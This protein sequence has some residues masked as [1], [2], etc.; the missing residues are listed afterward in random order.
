MIRSILAADPGKLDE[1]VDAP[2]LTAHERSILKDLLEILTPFEEATDFSQIEHHPSAGYVLPCI[3]GLKHQL[4]SMASRYNSSFLSALKTSLN[5]RMN[6]FE[7]NHIYQL[8]APD[9]NFSG[10]EMMMNEEV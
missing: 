5:R 3:R 1:L 2:K 4:N 8:A 9:L 10:V 7:L 6:A